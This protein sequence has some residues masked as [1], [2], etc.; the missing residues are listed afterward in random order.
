[1]FQIPGGKDSADGGNGHG[2]NGADTKGR[3]KEV[4]GR[5]DSDKQEVVIEP[6]HLKDKL[7]YLVKLKKAAD[8]ASRDFNDAVK[9][10]AKKSGFL[11]TVVRKV[12]VAKAGE[13]FEEAQR[14][15]EQMELAFEEAAKTA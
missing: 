15:A 14:V 8:E 3:K 13:G 6:K 7:G 12:A 2:G 10:V 5:K 1:M 4:K 9:A 11:A